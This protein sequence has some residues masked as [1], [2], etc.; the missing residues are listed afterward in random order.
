MSKNLITNTNK[1][2]TLKVGNHT[3]QTLTIDNETYSP[4]RELLVA[5]GVTKEESVSIYMNTNNRNYVRN[6]KNNSES[7]QFVYTLKFKFKDGKYY[8]TDSLNLKD[9]FKFVATLLPRNKALKDKANRYFFKMEEIALGKAPTDKERLES[10]QTRKL[11]TDV[12]STLSANHLYFNT[13]T[14]YVYKIAFGMDSAEIRKLFNL[15]EKAVVRKFLSDKCLNHV[16][17]IEGM[18]ASQPIS[19]KDDLKKL[20]DSIQL[21]FKPIKIEVR[22]DTKIITKEE[23][24]LLTKDIGGNNIND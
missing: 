1:Y 14:N 2:S 19:T 23:R 9:I 6:I 5:L 24:V 17:A 16:K 18:I 12:I 3:I 10:K 13:A 11:F 15:S 22:E 8:N 7:I 4:I 21:I 20:K